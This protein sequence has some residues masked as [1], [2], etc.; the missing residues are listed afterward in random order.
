MGSSSELH[1]LGPTQSKPHLHGRRRPSD[2]HLVLEL[3]GRTSKCQRNWPGVG[4]LAADELRGPIFGVWRGR[5]CPPAPLVPVPQQVD[6]HSLPAQASSAENMIG[7]V[8]D[9][10]KIC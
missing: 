8:L 7:C 5:P 6:I 9:S 4:K 3:T 10:I 1:S 2:S